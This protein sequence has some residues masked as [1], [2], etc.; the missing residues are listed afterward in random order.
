MGLLIAV[1]CK[2]P[3]FGSQWTESEFFSL[4]NRSV[5]VNYP[6]NVESRVNCA[7]QSK[8]QKRSSTAKT[9]CAH[10]ETKSFKLQT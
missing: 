7:F 5:V 1:I 10:S 9:L 6:C 2:I 8:E 4:S 3:H